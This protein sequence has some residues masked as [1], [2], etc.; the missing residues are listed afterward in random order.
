MLDNRF[1]EDELNNFYQT[2]CQTILKYTTIKN[3]DL[4]VKPINTIYDLVLNYFANSMSDEASL[5]LNL[6]LNTNDNIDTTAHAVQKA[7][8]TVTLIF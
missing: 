8:R 4:M 5:A 1:S 2:F 6:I 7:V 3:T